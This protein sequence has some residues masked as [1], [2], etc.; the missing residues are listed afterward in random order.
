MPTP[1]EGHHVI[2]MHVHRIGDES[3]PHPELEVEVQY[4]DGSYETIGSIML[5]SAFSQWW[6]F[7]RMPQFDSSRCPKCG[8]H[9][10]WHKTTTKINEQKELIGVN[11]CPAEVD[12]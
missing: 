12:A 4:S 6:H 7:E 1:P 3:D 9:W 8:E 10:Q 5:E 11:I 2:G